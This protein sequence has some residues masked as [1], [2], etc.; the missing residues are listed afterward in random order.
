MIFGGFGHVINRLN[1]FGSP[2]D[3][4]LGSSMS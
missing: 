4:T 2:F 3:R 1:A